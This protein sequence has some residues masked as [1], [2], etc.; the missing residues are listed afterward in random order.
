M[1]GTVCRPHQSLPLS[2]SKSAITAVSP[3]SPSNN[4]EPAKTVAATS[5]PASFT[6]HPPAG[7][8]SRDHQPPTSLHSDRRTTSQRRLH[9]RS[10]Q[11]PPLI[12][13]AAISVAVSGAITSRDSASLPFHRSHPCPN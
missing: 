7:P 8:A 3:I 9:R 2:L 13:A 11:P 4:G 12:H 10:G 1:Y 6:R 5:P